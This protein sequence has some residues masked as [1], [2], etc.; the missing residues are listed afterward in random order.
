MHSSIL[1]WGMS[2][3]EELGGLS[4]WGLKDSDMTERACHIHTCSETHL[5]HLGQCFYMDRE[6]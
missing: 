5:K 2:W 6:R 4:P 3:I 1:V